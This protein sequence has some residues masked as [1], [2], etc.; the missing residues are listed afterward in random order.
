MVV[1]GVIILLPQLTLAEECCC[2][3]GGQGIHCVTATASVTNTVTRTW[4]VT[5]TPNSTSTGTATRTATPTP[6]NTSTSTATGT[7]TDTPTITQTP[8]VTPTAQSLA[9]WC[10]YA[11]ACWHMDDAADST[12]VNDP[13]TSCGSTC[14]LAVA[15][16]VARDT[17]NKIQGTAAA[18]GDGTET[19]SCAFATCGTQLNLV[20]G[21]G[22]ASW[23][24]YHRSTTDV[25]TGDFRFAGSVASGNQSYG[26]GRDNTN[27]S[28]FC[29]VTQANT[30]RI[31][32]DGSDNTYTVNN[33]AWSACVFD[34]TGNTLSTCSGS[35]CS[36]TTATDIRTNGAGA[37]GE[38][39][40]ASLNGQ[41]DDI[42]IFDECILTATDLCRLCSCA[43][44][45]SLCT[46]QNSD[47]TLYQSTG[48]RVALCNS[49]TLPNCNQVA[50]GCKST[51]TPTPAVTATST[52]TST[53]TATATPTPVSVSFSASCSIG[54]C[55]TADNTS[56]AYPPAGIVSIFSNFLNP[57][58]STFGGSFEVGVGLIRWDTSS[59]TDG[60]TILSCTLE[61]TT[62]AGAIL[63]DDTRSLTAAWTTAESPWSASDYDVNAGTDAL[64]GTALSTF[65]SNTLYD[66]S[67]SNCSNVD[68]TGYTGVK[69]WVSGGQPTGQNYM[70]IKTSTVPKLL[71]T[72]T[73]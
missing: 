38:F 68:T 6:V 66:L 48:Q 37:G 71:V 28:P 55:A 40:T 10:G 9:N 56:N 73:P 64:S 53:I 22:N 11:L 32:V 21:G 45:G 5:N 58:R 35:G 39:F 57:N 47:P 50:P 23:G 7:I 59:I 26:M 43:T 51:F 46:C 63:N 8:T 24:G 42:F 34:D 16:T 44:D 14:D 65:S 15:N 12:R 13:L 62:A 70:E 33:Y 1:A 3:S 72:Y 17:T 49:C 19:L 4:T 31:A 69:L 41:L 30:T 54:D 52:R 18:S 2:C 61:F 36:S 25:A 67:L 27:D 60:A 29:T 20:G